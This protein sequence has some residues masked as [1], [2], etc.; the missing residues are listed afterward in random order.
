MKIWI[1]EGA[2][3]SAAFREA[4]LPAPS[5]A[6]GEVMLRVRAVG[7]NLVDR[8]PKA[9]H[10]SHTPPAPAAIP[11]MEAAG[12]IAALGDDA[13]RRPIGARVMAMVQ[14]GC[15]EYVCV[16]ESLLMDVP[17]SM[18]WSDAAAI[19]VSFL[20]AHDALV[21]QGRLAPGNAVLVQG[22]TTGVGLAAIQLARLHGA[23]L[24]AGTSR[25]AEKLERARSW[26]L[27]LPIVSGVA[28]AMLGA[29]AGRGADVVLDHLGARVLNET[30]RATAVGG[31]VVNIGRYAGTRGEIDL[32]MLA[33]RRISL[34]GVT[35]RTR[36]LEEHAAIVA[37]FVRQHAAD[38]EAGRLRPVIDRVMAFDELPAA[39]ERAASGQQ[40]GK[41]VLER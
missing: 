11:G 15:A 31:R 5:P 29:T 9:Q 36:S 27:Q 8:F 12:E 14:G 28:E 21:T 19:P 16:H 13:R 22:A 6:R 18:S 7:L 37:D 33:L 39:I 40:F 1:G 24:I 4:T 10:F 25:S 23:S 35:F 3:R 26:G 30:L 38:L 32:E 41:L 2:G 17:P 34:I 20:T